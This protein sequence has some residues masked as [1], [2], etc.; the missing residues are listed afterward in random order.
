ML[1][2]IHT[3]LQHIVCQQPLDLDY[4]EFVCFQEAVLFSAASNQVLI[5]KGILDALTE[6]HKLVK[7]AVTLDFKRAKLFRTPLRIWAGA[8]KRSFLNYHN[9][10]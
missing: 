5:P 3:R 1:E 2:R 8:I 6:L 9:M 10:D 7:G 4:L